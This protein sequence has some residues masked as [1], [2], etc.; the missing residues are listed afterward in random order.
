[1]S[2][3]PFFNRVSLLI[4]MLCVP[5]LFEQDLKIRVYNYNTQEL[6]H[7]FEA[8]SDYIRGLA[9]HPTL[10]LVLSCSD[11][12]SLKLWNWDKQ[13]KLERQFDGHSHYV[14]GCEFNPRDPQ[15][16][17]SASLD[18]TVRMWSINSANSLYSFDAHDRGVNCVTFYRGPGDRPYIATGADDFAVRL[19]DVQTKHLVAK[20]EGHTNN[21]SCVAFLPHLPLLVS[22][23]EDGTVRLWNTVTLRHEQTLN[24]SKD[25]CWA[26][27][28]M[29][30]SSQLAL[31]YDEGAIII[32]LGNEEPTASLD[33][34]TGRIVYASQSEVFEGKL[35]SLSE[36]NDGEIVTMATR[37]LGR[38]DFLPQSIQHAPNGRLL[39]CFFFWFLIIP[40]PS[41][42]YLIASTF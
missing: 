3:F 40:P 41:R 37:E 33:A 39:V 2:V 32:R 8:H 7:A 38:C 15:Q 4:K 29:R 17:A 6:V 23:S 31:G 24:Y 13:W 19:F 22:G 10:P 25:R 36:V 30:T 26:C 34:N 14:M 1:M 28:V 12:F 35:R 21:I 42:W 18:R 11:D 27:A 5:L 20:L 16:F 9:V